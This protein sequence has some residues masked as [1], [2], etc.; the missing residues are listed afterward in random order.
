MVWLTTSGGVTI[1]AIINTKTIAYFDRFLKK[2]GVTSPSF[3]KKN[4]M[5][6]SKTSHLKRTDVLPFRYKSHVN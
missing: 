5:G 1:A 4:M 3:V 2:E 6:G